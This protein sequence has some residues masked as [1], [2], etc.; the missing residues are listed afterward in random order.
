M[1]NK[2]S[3]KQEKQQNNGG[4]KRIMRRRR[5][6]GKK[7]KNNKLDVSCSK[8]P[9]KKQRIYNTFRLV[10]YYMCTTHVGKSEKV[11]LTAFPYHNFSEY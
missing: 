6:K 10:P 1:K 8:V 9:F 11:S 4:K 7:N 5:G 2:R 3:V